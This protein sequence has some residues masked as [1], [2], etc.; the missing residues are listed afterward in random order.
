M[1]QVYVISRLLCSRF[2]EGVEEPRTS[3]RYN[4]LMFMLQGHITE[5]LAGR[6]WEQLVQT[7]IFDKVHHRLS[8]PKETCTESQEIQHTLRVFW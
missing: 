8:Y 4:N 7:E 2:I 6:S 5:L 1:I 3:F